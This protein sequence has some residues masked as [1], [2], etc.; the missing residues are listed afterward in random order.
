MD[1]FLTLPPDLPPR[2]KELALDIT[3][4]H[5]DSFSRIKALESYLRT[6][7]SYNINV[8]A[9]PENRDFVDYFLFDRTEGYCTS[10]AT[11][12]AVMAR[13]VGVPTRY[14]EGFVL[15]ETA[16]RNGIYQVAG[17]SAHAWVEAYIAG[18]GWLT[19]EPTPGFPTSD[20]LPRRQNQQTGAPVVSPGSDAI[21]TPSEG[22][23]LIPLIPDDFA[24]YN[25]DAE[26][27]A[28]SSLLNAMLFLLLVTGLA[29]I[30]FLMLLA[31]FRWLL[32]RKN[33][34]RL[35]QL[36]PRLRAVGYY[37]LTLSLLERLGLGKYPGETPREYSDRIF[38]RVYSWNMSF[39]EISEGINHSLYSGKDE[40]P[41]WLAEQMEEFYRSILDRYIASVG[42]VT[43]FREIYLQKKY[44]LHSSW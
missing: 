33:I 1:P 25:P 39:K 2:V 13:V 12:L 6:N 20:S 14:V 21:K 10:F 42:R 36:P 17:T 26:K 35:N 34:R 27:S 38:R 44:Y 28:A 23:G 19:F 5:G 15:P 24:P 18:I 7:Y 40:A 22:E 31:L 11:A 4:G 9:L 30:S 32:I 37:N 43:A 41:P 29:A 16:D 3:A 8:P